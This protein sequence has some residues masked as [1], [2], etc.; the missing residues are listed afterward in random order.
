MSKRMIWTGHVARMEEKRY[1][2][3]ISMGKPEG[4]RPF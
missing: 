2:C 3:R 1:T 4:K